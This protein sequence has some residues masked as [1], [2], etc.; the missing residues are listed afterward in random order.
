MTCYQSH[1]RGYVT[2]YSLVPLVKWPHLRSITALL[3]FILSIQLS[4]V[5]ISLQQLMLM[6]NKSNYNRRT[7]LVYEWRSGLVDDGPEWWWFGCWL[8]ETKVFCLW[9]QSSSWMKWKPA[10]TRLLMKPITWRA[11]CPLRLR[12]CLLGTLESIVRWWFGFRQWNL[13]I[14]PKHQISMDWGFFMGTSIDLAFVDNIYQ[15]QYNPLT[16]GFWWR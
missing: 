5:S 15:Q 8:L 10:S 16:C 14:R 6:I 1:S 7:F 4:N 13:E 9:Q 3:L 11:I 12:G 2:S